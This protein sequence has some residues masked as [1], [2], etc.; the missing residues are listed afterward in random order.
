MKHQPIRRVAVSMNGITIAYVMGFVNAVLAA[1]AA[2]GVNLSPQETAA[3]AG[4]LNAGLVLAVH[5]GHRVGEGVASGASS[6]T[7][8]ARSDQQIARADEEA[9]EAVQA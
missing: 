9:K 3:L 5:V 2:F 1:V 4:L 7:S 8:Q 6:R